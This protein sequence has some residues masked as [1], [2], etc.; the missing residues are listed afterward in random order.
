MFESRRF[1]LIA[2]RPELYAY[3]RIGS[4]P[5]RRYHHPLFCR[6]RQLVLHAMFHLDKTGCQWRSL[7]HDLPS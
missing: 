5:D 1:V 3:R 2:A 6:K 4:K 7:P